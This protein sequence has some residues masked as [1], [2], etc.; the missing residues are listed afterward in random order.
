MLTKILKTNGKTLMPK[1]KDLC[2]PWKHVIY[3]YIIYNVIHTY[4]IYIFNIHIHYIFNIHIH[5][6]HLQCGKKAKEHLLLLQAAQHQ[7]P[8]PTG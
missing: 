5:Y 4:I 1:N 7:L 3:T 8:E 6:I 2:K